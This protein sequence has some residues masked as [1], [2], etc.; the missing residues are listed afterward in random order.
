MTRMSGPSHEFDAFAGHYDD[1]LSQGLSV[2]G[3][4]K[5]YFA[6]GRMCW[7]R[8]CLNQLQEDV[9]SV[10]D[11]GCG[12]GSNAQWL[13]EILK[14]SEVVGVDCSG[15]MV[16][17]AQGKYGTEQSR[18]FL[19]ED[20]CSHGEL[21]LAFCNGVFHHIPVPSRRAAVR[22]IHRCLKPNGLFAFWENNPW[23]PGTRYVM[24]RIPFDRDAIMLSARVA[25]RLLNDEGF[26]VLRTDFMFIFPHMLKWLRRIEPWLAP[27]P[28]G[29]QYQILCRKH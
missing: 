5:E 22:Y 18:F 24:S 16:R 10:L 6:K 17:L 2:S 7:L 4:D 28:C 8:R 15:G 14:C 12:D 29:A 21:D 3:E 26:D 13:L 27:L 1:A 20:Y 25:K 23:N 9:H 19:I 11:Y